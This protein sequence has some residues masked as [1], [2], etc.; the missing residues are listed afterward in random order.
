ML[1]F[2][3]SIRFTVSKHSNDVMLH[4]S[5]GYRKIYCNNYLHPH[6]KSW[7]DILLI[8]DANKFILLHVLK[9]FPTDLELWWQ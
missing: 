3:V 4:P 1:L 5:L 9:Q 6:F 8:D 2:S 7:I